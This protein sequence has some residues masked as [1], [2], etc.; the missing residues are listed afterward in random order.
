MLYVHN[1][2]NTWNSSYDPGYNGYYEIPEGMDKQS[3]ESEC[4]LAGSSNLNLL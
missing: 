2:C 1:D 4:Y 3:E